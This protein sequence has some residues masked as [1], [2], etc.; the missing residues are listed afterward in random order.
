MAQLSVWIP[1][2]RYTSHLNETCELDSPLSGSPPVFLS[3]AS[4]I[5]GVSVDVSHLLLTACSPRSSLDSS[6]AIIS[7]LSSTDGDRGS[8]F[9]PSAPTHI[10]LYD[11]DIKLGPCCYI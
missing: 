9:P 2:G 4:S 7:P 6:D 5:R 8:P 10:S 3:M 1:L 11:A